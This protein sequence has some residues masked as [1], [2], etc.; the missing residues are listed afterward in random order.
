VAPEADAVDF[1][2]RSKEP[3][4]MRDAPGDVATATLAPGWHTATLIALMLGVAA[5]GTIL[6][7]SGVPVAAAVG[8]SR[9]TGVYL[10]ML[11][12][13]WGLCFYVA[14]FGR[15]R[16]ALRALLGPRWDAASGVAADAGVAVLLFALIEG[17]EL[18]VAHLGAGALAGRAALVPATGAERLAW[19]A[20]ALSAGFCEEVVYRGYLQTQIAAFTRRPSAGVVGQALLF[21]LAHG[22]QGWAIAA[23]FAVYGAALGVVARWRRTLRA[24][25][26]CHVGI[27]L[28]GGLLAR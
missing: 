3:A 5:L 14:R 18:A 13:Q 8:G 7:V 17:A 22:E 9:I 24:G 19:V 12:V 23:R 6:A 21:G 16:S 11:G 25:V 20:V 26:L 28:V 10:P 1:S 4:V 2:S 15:P 27:D